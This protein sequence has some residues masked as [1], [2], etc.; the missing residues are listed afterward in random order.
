MS[1]QSPC[2]VNFAESGLTVYAQLFDSDGAAY[3]NEITTGIVNLEVGGNPTRVYQL[4]ATVPDNFVGSCLLYENGDVENG[5]AVAI[6]PQETENA[7]VKT[8]TRSSHS[9]ANVV[10]AMQA[11]A[12]DFKADVSALATSAALATVDSLVDAIKA[13][14]DLLP[15]GG[16]LT[17]LLNNVSAILA[18]TTELQTDWTNGGRL[19]LILDAAATQV[20]VDALNDL[21]AAQVNAEVDT[22]I[23]DAALATASALATVDTNVDSVLSAVSSGGVTISSATMNAIADALLSRS[24]SNVEDTASTH[25]LA[26]IILAML[27]SAAPSTTWTIY[28]T[29]GSTTFNTRTLTEDDDASAVVAVS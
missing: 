21:S 13:V 17:T 9:A 3:G 18:D 4:I 23:S 2:A 5:A 24:V 22:A 28:K 12:N 14:T 27:K 1:Y 7:D 16:A 11:V 6:S 20:S 10:T 29:D 19:D 26:E 15:D 25:S 8:S